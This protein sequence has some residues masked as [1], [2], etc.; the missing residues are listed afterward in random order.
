VLA[1]ELEQHVDV[2]Q[3]RQQVLTQNLVIPDNG[4]AETQN[5]LRFHCVNPKPRYQNLQFD[6]RRDV[7]ERRSGLAV[8]FPEIRIV[9]DDS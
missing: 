6:L 2:G 5:S 9:C 1:E 3:P 4:V 8:L 7:P